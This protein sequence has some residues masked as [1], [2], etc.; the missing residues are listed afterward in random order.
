[1]GEPMRFRASQSKERSPSQSKERS[2]LSKHHTI[3]PD[4]IPSGA[5]DITTCKDLSASA[6]AI[7][8]HRRPMLP[9]SIHNARKSAQLGDKRALKDEFDVAAFGVVVRPTPPAIYID[10]IT[11]PFQNMCPS[12]S[13]KHQT[14]AKRTGLIGYTDHLALHRQYETCRQPD[15]GS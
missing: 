5:S 10:C 14:R 15:K 8:T 1:M 7:R 9:M 12:F 2:R 3:G 11:E 13:L 6:F 4:N